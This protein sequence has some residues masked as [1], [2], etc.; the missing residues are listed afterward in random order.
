MTT[1]SAAIMAHPKRIEM[2]GELRAALDRDVP[3]VWDEVN[4]RHDTGIR[5]LEAFDAAADWHV[6]IQ[7][8]VEPAPDLLAGIEQALAHVPAECPVSFYIGRVRPFAAKVQR[9]V[10]A[11]G[12]DVSWI[13]MDDIYWGP[14]L[15]IPTAV[16]PDISEWWH[17]SQV[18]NYDR[19]LSRWFAHPSRRR[20]CWYSWP[21]LV[22][23]RGDESLSGHVAV[24][25]AHRFAPGS[26]T[27]FDWSGDVVRMRHTGRLD[28]QRQ[29]FARA[30]GR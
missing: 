17:R 7:D 21:S 22:D 11:A 19:R 15:A 27:D 20:P 13:V 24:R 5:S 14:C 4:D 6:V 23:H 1:L 28:R 8:D 12:D 3:V 18:T 25:R 16:I 2:V 29:A 9:A 30:A 26:A 10:Q